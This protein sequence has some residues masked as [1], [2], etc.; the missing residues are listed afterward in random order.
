MSAIKLIK[1]K[2]KKN[3]VLKNKKAITVRNPSVADLGCLSR[4]QLIPSRIPDPHP[5]Q[6]YVAFLALKTVS[7]LSE[8][9]CGMFNPG[10][11]IWIRIFFSIPDSGSREK[12]KHRI[13]DPDPQ[14]C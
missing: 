14:H 5:H 1:V 3:F 4:I 2:S 8:K 12:K 6:R 7:K 9:L 10:S 11:R 13:P